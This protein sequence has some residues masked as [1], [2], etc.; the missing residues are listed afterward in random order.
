MHK[1]TVLVLLI[2][3][4]SICLLGCSNE[5][6]SSKKK[7]TVD[8]DSS[9]FFVPGILAETSQ[10][11]EGPAT[12]LFCRYWPGELTLDDGT[13]VESTNKYYVRKVGSGSDSLYYF[14][15]PSTIYDAYESGG[16]GFD[17]FRCLTDSAFMW[18]LKTYYPEIN[19]D[20]YPFNITNAKAFCDS[21]MS[22]DFIE[23]SPEDVHFDQPRTTVFSDPTKLGSDLS[24]FECSCINYNMYNLQNE[25]ESPITGNEFYCNTS[26]SF[27]LIYYPGILSDY[28]ERITKRSSSGSEFWT[29]LEIYFPGLDTQNPKKY[30]ETL[31][32]HFVEPKLEDYLEY[33]K[34]HIYLIK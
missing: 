1:K 33:Y 4:L 8:P 9:E 31:V 30:V 17:G 25:D 21:I 23:P 3:A 6:G 27:V 16:G 22:K 28:Y 7:N 18:Y 15:Y 20:S 19:L 14:Y 5:A 11:T 32:G 24:G 26:W 13:V 34:T 29:Y 12:V 10:V 2:V